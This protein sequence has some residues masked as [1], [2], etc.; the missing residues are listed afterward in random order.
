MPIAFHSPVDIVESVSANR[1]IAAKKLLDH[2]TESKATQTDGEYKITMNV[3]LNFVREKDSGAIEV[4]Q[5]S[6]PD[7]ISVKLSE[8]QLQ[9]IF[10]WDYRK[11]V[12]LL[13]ARFSDF[14]TNAKFYGIKAVLEKDERLCRTDCWVEHAISSCLTVQICTS[15][16][17]PCQDYY[18]HWSL[19]RYR[20]RKR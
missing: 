6:D 4:R 12:D 19:P 7:A 2:I 17:Y 9:S 5:S 3:S 14:T 18:H 11:L 20:L 8:E 15:L 10:P 16:P 1:S 13:S